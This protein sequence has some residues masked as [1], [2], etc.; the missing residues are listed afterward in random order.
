MNLNL[1]RHFEDLGDFLQYAFTLRLIIALDSSNDTGI[2]M[3][4]QDLRANFIQRRFDGL[5]LADHIDTISIFFDHA[6][7]A[8]QMAFDG[9]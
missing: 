7:D 1:G 6:N 8:T 4:L 2:E 9:L 3:P 5:H